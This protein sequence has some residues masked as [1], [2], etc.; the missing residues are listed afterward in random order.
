[1]NKRIYITGGASGIGFQLAKN[2]VLQGADVTIF[3][4]QAIENAEASL[5]MLAQPKQQIAGYSLD[6]T[7]TAS[8]ATAFEKA[9]ATAPPDILIHCA[10]I[11]LAK[12]FESTTEAE[13]TRV[14]TVN[15]LGTRHVAAAAIPLLKEGGQL[16]LIASM[17]GLVGCYG[18]SAYCAAKH[19]VV[20][21]AEVLRIELKSRGIDV[22]VV[23]PP[24]VD[25]PMVHEERKDRPKETEAMKLLA[26]TL[27]VEAAC[28]YIMSGI[29]QRK[30]K[31]IPGSRARMLWATNKLLPG[32]VT[33]WL[34]DTTVQR[35]TTRKKP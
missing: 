15:L 30:F 33:R 25:T 1:M 2:Y 17:A 26:G 4:I 29:S 11:A 27:N 19:G 20:G 7:D 8:I 23:C 22:S 24:E 18:Y 9:A 35:T 5:K 12:S 10:G 31:I 34:S 21:L 3:D 6:V 32:S 16:V 28:K 14:I 13:Y